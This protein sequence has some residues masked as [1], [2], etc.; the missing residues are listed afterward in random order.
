MKTLFPAIRVSDLEA[1]LS[2]Y[3][4]V[5]YDVVGTV[6]VN[7]GTRLAMLAL[8][9]DAEVSLELVYRPADGPVSPRGLDH[10]AVQVD[11][12]EAAREWL[13]AGALEPGEVQTPG[14]ADGPRTSWVADPDGYRLELVQ[15]PDGH[16]VGMTR[17][18]LT[19]ARRPDMPSG[20]VDETV[21]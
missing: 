2:F 1:S 16:P 8:P 14:G 10:L 21:S 17:V 4:C 13:L 6:V 15:W 19:E 12:L 3:R 5:G 11:D 9:G 20:G 7:A 18:D